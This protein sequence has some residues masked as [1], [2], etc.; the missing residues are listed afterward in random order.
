MSQSKKINLKMWRIFRVIGCHFLTISLPAF[1]QNVTIKKNI[2]AH[3]SQNTLQKRTCTMTKKRYPKFNL[4]KP[5]T[6]LQQDSRDS[7]PPNRWALEQH[8]KVGMNNP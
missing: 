8:L 5:L 3:I 6:L 1:D 4:S 2:G 7:F